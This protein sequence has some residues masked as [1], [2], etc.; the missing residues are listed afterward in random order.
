MTTDPVERLSS[1]LAAT[2]QVIAD[3]PEDLWAAPTPCP[4][5]DVR[6]VVSHVVAGNNMF[7]SILHGQSPSAPRDDREPNGDLLGAYKDSADS[8]LIA[9]RR[10]GVLEHVFAVPIGSVPGLVALHLRTIEVLVH[11]WDLARATGR[12]ARFPE[13]IAEEELIFS[14]TKLADIPPDRRPFAPSQ[15]VA[16][17][18][19]AIDRLAACLGRDVTTQTYRDRS[20]P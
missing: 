13:A 7:A 16:D 15:P 1:G 19:P 5:W 2:G 9:F 17:D 14:Q 18:A 4:E 6:A 20:R 8:L 3:V 12:P 10:P 11:G